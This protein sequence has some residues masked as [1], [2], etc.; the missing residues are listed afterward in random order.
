M[1]LTQGIIN[2]FQQIIFNFFKHWCALITLKIVALRKF[3]GFFDFIL[4]ALK[5]NHGLPC[6]VQ[7]LYIVKSNV[8]S[9]L[10]FGVFL[11]HLWL[12]D[13][14]WV[15]TIFLTVCTLLLHSFYCFFI[16]SYNILWPHTYSLIMLT[17]NLLSK[18]CL[19]IQFCC[20]KSGLKKITIYCC[21]ELESGN[22]LQKNIIKL[23]C[24]FRF[25]WF[26]SLFFSNDQLSI[27]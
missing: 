6:L 27:I 24:L 1:T 14:H 19:C 13:C 16:K 2:L 4:A 22:I 8:I 25:L 17:R 10:C 7:I 12:K 5:Y 23:T 20:K 15:K 26:L 11:F 21:F 9:Y 18:Y 3:N